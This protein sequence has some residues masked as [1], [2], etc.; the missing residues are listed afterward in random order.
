MTWSAFN[1]YLQDKYY[2]MHLI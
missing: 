2:L 1:I